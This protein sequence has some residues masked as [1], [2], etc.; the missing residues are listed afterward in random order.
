MSQLRQRSDI[1]DFTKRVRWRLE[2]QQTGLFRECTFPS[3]GI[4]DGDEIDF[5]P[6][7]RQYL[8]K[9]RYG[10]S[11]HLGGGHYVIAAAQQRESQQQN[12]RHSRCRCNTPRSR[13]QRSQSIFKRTDR[14]IGKARIDI[15]R[16]GFRE[17]GSRLG[18][19]LKN[20][21]GGRKDRVAVFPFWGAILTRPNCEGLLISLA[22]S[23]CHAT[24]PCSFDPCGKKNPRQHQPERGISPRFSRFSIAPAS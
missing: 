2:K 15:S 24:A 20:E 10:G 8:G 13:F 5:D 11:E 19:V 9:Q 12:G 1:S 22:V 14:R 23:F 7:A 21:T 17:A 6:K 3:P 16:L 4:R 18:R